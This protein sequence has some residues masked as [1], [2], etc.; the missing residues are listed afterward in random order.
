MMISGEIAFA[1]KMR[2]S[3][4]IEDEYGLRMVE[5]NNKKIK[6]KIFDGTSSGLGIGFALGLAM[7][8]PLSVS[9]TGGLPPASLVER[10]E[11]YIDQRT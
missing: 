3:Q 1:P 4:R 2:L 5:W 7:F 8:P 9:R 10:E 6:M 11:A